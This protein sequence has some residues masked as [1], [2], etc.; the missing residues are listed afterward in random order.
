MKSRKIRILLGKLGEGHKQ[1]ILNLAKSLSEG[2]FEVIYTELAEP[3]AIVNAALQESVDH[4]GIT[5]LP[6]ADMHG[7]EKIIG[8]LRKEKAENISVT[9][10]GYME[11][12]DI[13]RIME[14][15]VQT[16]FPK[17]T[18]FDELIEWAR[19]NIK[20]RNT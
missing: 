18:A 14:M 9:A 16:F 4:I 2:G 5:L 12:H 17:G 15:G 11:D 8:L 1:S 13:P 10:G 20:L 6:G 7:L 3:G 19:K